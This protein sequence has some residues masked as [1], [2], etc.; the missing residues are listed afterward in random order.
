[1]PCV[2]IEDLNRR[3]SRVDFSIKFDNPTCYACDPE[4]VKAEFI[5][6]KRIYEDITGRKQGKNIVLFQI[7]QSFKPGEVTAEQAHKIAYELAMSFTKGKH[8]FVV[9]T[10]TDKAHIHTH[11]DF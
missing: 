8:A 4:T 9:A 7:R 5:L 2:Q 6:S 10:H 3:P 1:M 11:I